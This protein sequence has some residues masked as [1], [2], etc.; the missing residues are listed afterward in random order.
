MML[1]AVAATLWPWGNE[2]KDE[3]LVAIMDLQGLVPK[4]KVEQLN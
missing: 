2:H 4:G 1:G 3:Q